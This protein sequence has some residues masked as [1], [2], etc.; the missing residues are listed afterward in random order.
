MKSSKE[1]LT[2]RRIKSLSIADSGKGKTYFIG[3]MID[4]D[5][6]PYIIATEKGLGTICDKE[7]DYEEVND[8]NS[9]R[10]ELAWY[11]NNYKEHG[12]DCLVIDSLTKAQQYLIKSVIGEATKVTQPQWGEIKERMKRLVQQ[13]VDTCPTSFHMTVMA[14]E[15]EDELTGI[16][17]VM[18]CLDGA[19]RNWLPG[20]F[21]IV[22]YHDCGLK[23]GE[24]QYW[25]QT[26]GDQRII[27]RNRYDK[28]K[29]LN[30]LEPNNYSVIADIFQGGKND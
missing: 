22:L 16:K 11:Y 10:Q 17:K 12:Y 27:A 14:Q 24:T 3:T 8:W 15:S 2:D 20:E 21:D 6:K 19:I 13:I 4:C 30:R 9:L 23:G 26:Q 25:V 5:V 29:K 7:F 28:L 1:L 18:P